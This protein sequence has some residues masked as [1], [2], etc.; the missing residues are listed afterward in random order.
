MD[1]VLVIEDERPLR[2]IYREM[3][4]KANFEV[5][6]AINGKIGIELYKKN[7]TDLVITDLL[8]P[9]GD[10]IEVLLELKLKPNSPKAKII[11]ISGST[12]RSEIRMLNFV[13]DLHADGVL[14]KPVSRAELLKTVDRVLGQK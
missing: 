7:P 6:E 8:M 13:G 1:S 3:L 4:T 14:F 11:I 10:G 12:S 9:E 5:I 2:N